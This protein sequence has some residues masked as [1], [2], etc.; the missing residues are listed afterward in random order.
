[1]DSTFAGPIGAVCCFT[2]FVTEKL[3]Q[4][5]LKCLSESDSSSETFAQASIS[6]V[7]QK[8]KDGRSSL[9]LC[10]LVR[11]FVKH[12]VASNRLMKHGLLQLRGA[13]SLP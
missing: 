4:C 6:F 5:F 10:R 12:S 7:T 2:F 9:L 11:L 1:M 3:F 13:P 8:P